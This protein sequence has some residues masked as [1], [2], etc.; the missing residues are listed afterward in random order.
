MFG[1][2]PTTSP[3]LGIRHT[4]TYKMSPKTESAVMQDINKAFEYI[5]ALLPPEHKHPQVGLIC[6]SGLSGL[7]DLFTE[8]RRILYSHIPGFPRSS[9]A[10]HQNILKIG[11]LNGATC[12]MFLGRF[13]EYEGHCQESITLPVRILAKLGV[14]NLIITN[15]SGSL[16]G[17][18][19]KVGDFVAIKDHIS[20][21]CMSGSNPL[22]GPNLSEFGSRRTEMSKCYH[23]LTF[24]LLME[25]AK[26]ADLDDDLVKKGVY[27]HI[28]GP[29]Y[30]SPAEVRMMKSLGGSVVGMSSVPEVLVAAQCKQIRNIFVISLVTDDPSDQGCSHE[31]VLAMAKERS[32]D[33]QKVIA[34][35]LQLIVNL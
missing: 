7:S 1:G 3:N 28:S 10:G 33:L 16:D 31:A 8:S 24:D 9:V 15:S 4:H 29:N 5:S 21:P 6:G 22:V 12:I 18:K 2:T 19:Y 14:P 11:H 20:F 32:S 13:H 30:E 34:E 26:K 23:P 17:E 27:F 25:A 35:F